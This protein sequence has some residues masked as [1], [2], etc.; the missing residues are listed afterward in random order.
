VKVVKRSLWIAGIVIAAS[1]SSIRA[2][3]TTTTP[4]A[5]TIVRAPDAVRATVEHWLASE[6]CGTPLTVRIIPTEGQLYI[7][8]QDDRGRVHE[9]TVPD[10]DSA[11]VLIASWT[12]DA[13]LV[14]PP[15]TDS[16]SAGEPP[17]TLVQPAQPSDP[18]LD[19]RPLVLVD[20]PHTAAPAR[21]PR[22]LTLAVGAGSGE[23][24]GVRA[25]LEVL[26]RGGFTA[27]VQ[28]ELSAAAM[29]AIADPQSLGSYAATFTDASAMIGARYTWRFGDRWH[30]RAGVAAGL[31]T[32][33]VSLTYIDSTSGSSVTSSSAAALTPICE[34]ALLFG[35]S[36]GDRWELELGPVA[37]LAPQHWYMVNQMETLIRTPGSVLA[38]AG[39]RRAL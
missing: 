20:R 27:D 9:R 11:G 8:A 33:Q 18:H 26:Q 29:N 17:Q 4:C 19:P 25:E 6:H 39:V 1:A 23:G 28:L 7:Y 34:G 14:A 38:Y 5:V 3:P 12:A 10:A 22:W 35:H 24:H 36:L 37:T 31:V 13:G 30:V 16:P 32:T 2:E 15:I 21:R